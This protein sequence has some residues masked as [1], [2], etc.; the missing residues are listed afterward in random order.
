L[1]ENT[2]LLVTSGFVQVSIFWFLN[3]LREKYTS[4]SALQTKTSH[5]LFQDVYSL[6]PFDFNVLLQ[7][8]IKGGADWATARGPQHLGGPQYLSR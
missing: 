7:W 3:S 8:R 5:S 6:V 1:Q 2:K 4:R